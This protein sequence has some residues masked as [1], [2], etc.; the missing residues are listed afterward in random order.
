MVKRQKRA[1]QPVKPFS[2]MKILELAA[3]ADK[4]PEENRKLRGM[5]QGLIGHLNERHM[6]IAA[7]QK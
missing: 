1:G 6:Q 4:S 2:E 7:M 3:K 5:V